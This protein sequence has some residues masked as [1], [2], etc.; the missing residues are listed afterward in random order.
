MVYIVLV[1]QDICVATGVQERARDTI[2]S[3]FISPNPKWS[4]T[5]IKER[6]TDITTGRNIREI[7]LRM[8][9]MY[10]LVGR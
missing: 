5:G 6:K 10:V 8:K 7:L 3:A 1:A 9:Y 2:C 4:P